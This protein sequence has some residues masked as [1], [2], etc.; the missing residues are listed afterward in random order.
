MPSLLQSF[1][2]SNRKNTL[3]DVFYL[4]FLDV[5]EA[6]VNLE[7]VFQHSNSSFAVL[8]CEVAG[9]GV[10]VF[11]NIRLVRVHVANQIDGFWRGS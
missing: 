10:R 5:W 8:L 7:V 3:L 4:I 11:F 2:K 9:S 6:G 1:F